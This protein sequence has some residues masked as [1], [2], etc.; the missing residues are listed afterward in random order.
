[1]IDISYPFLYCGA[2]LHLI[3]KTTSQDLYYVVDDSVINLYGRTGRKL[4]SFSNVDSF[5]RFLE[6]YI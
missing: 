5:I 4:R 6:N 1:M 3:N 2:L